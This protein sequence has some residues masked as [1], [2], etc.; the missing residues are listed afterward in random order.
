MP[1]PSEHPK[2][3]PQTTCARPPEQ[4]ESVSTPL[5]PPLQTSAV[6][7]LAGLDQVEALYGGEA[8]GFIY[9]RDG[10]PNA[11]QL[12]A[13]IAALEGAEAALVCASGMGAEAAVFLS[14]L[15]AGDHV[16]LSEGLYGRT[17]ALVNKELSRYGIRS[18]L[19]D[20]TRPETLRP[21]FE[22]RTKLVFVETLSNPL[23]RLADVAGAAAIA[24]A[25]GAKL[26]VDNTFAPLLCRPLELGADLVVHSATKLI[27]GHS[28]LTLGLLAGR[29]SLVER[30]SALA[31][32]FGLTGNPFE[33]WLAL[34]GSATLG[35][36]SERACANALNL[37]ERLKQHPRVRAVHYPGLPSHP[38]HS[39]AR[40]LLRG[41]FGTI[42]TI[43]LGG[44]EQA[45]TFIRALPHIPFAPSLG[46]VATTLS[47]PATTSHR[48]QTPEQW[49]RQGITPGLVR[50]SI[51]LEDPE[52]LWAEI[53]GALNHI[54][55]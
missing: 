34:R 53:E 42:A 22:A 35:V 27:G 49:A 25:G 50:L 23:V 51:G 41:G 6:Y 2:P 1:Q 33:S 9:A 3:R 48:G 10:H 31:S 47:H 14:C 17:V 18:S 29:K 52:D 16:A 7:C 36:R 11:S 38:D 19:F 13:K 39:R 21:A 46:D 54:K 8:R 45:D 44:R 26:V 32:T 5:A 43:D 15:D 55:D 37:A 4:P 12:A 24:H 20:S 30:A 28:D 40:E